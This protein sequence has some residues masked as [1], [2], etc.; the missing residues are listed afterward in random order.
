[1]TLQPNSSGRNLLLW[2]RTEPYS[3]EA[4]VVPWE[5]TQ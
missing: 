4:S 1:M 2:K 5:A 3:E